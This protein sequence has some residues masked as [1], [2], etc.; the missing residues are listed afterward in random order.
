MDGTG[1]ANLVAALRD[2][3]PRNLVYISAASARADSPSEFFRLKAAAEQCIRTSGLPYSIVRPAHLMDTW[4][5]VLGKPLARRGRA[6]TLGSGANPVS[7][8]AADDIARIVETLAA[9][10]GRGTSLDLGGPRPSPSTRSTTWSPPRSAGCPV[11]PGDAR[12]D[13]DR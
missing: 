3:P 1:I 7:F 13:P 10:G 12:G 6:L 2:Q 9:A 8:V 11:R 4:F 5:R